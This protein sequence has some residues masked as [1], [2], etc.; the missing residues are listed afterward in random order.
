M[1]THTIPMQWLIE[2]VQEYRNITKRNLFYKTVNLASSPSD[3]QWIRQLYYLSCDFTAAV[4]LR[5][6]SCHDARFRDAFGEHAAEEVTHPEELADWMR[7]SGLLAPD[8]Q[9]TSIPPT[10]ETLAL[11]SYFIRSVMRESIAHQII[12]LN[13]VAEGL[14]YDFYA[15][16]NPKLAE[17]GL[18]PKGYWLVHQE[19]DMKHQTLGLELIPEC[20]RNSLCG[21]GYTHTMWEVFSL[22]NQLLYSWSGMPV[23]HKPQLPT[24]IE[25]GSYKGKS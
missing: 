20:E 9:L 17:V 24:P 4:A 22:F 6:G 10:F 3:F 5:Y 18:T 16:V 25:L 13:L 19:S 23:E 8:E 15:I 1:L 11:G 2:L 21:R 7:E 14:A 12:T